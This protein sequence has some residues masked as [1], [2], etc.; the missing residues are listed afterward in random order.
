MIEGN[1]PQSYQQLVFHT[2]KCPAANVLDRWILLS[3]SPSGVMVLDDTVSVLPNYKDAAEQ[4]R[5]Q[6]EENEKRMT[7]KGKS[8]NSI[9]NHNNKII[10]SFFFVSS[11]STKKLVW[12][13]K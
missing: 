8:L 13:C 4:T 2:L 5:V 11:A 10:E 6:T 12:F 9:S 7:F 1:S 3:C